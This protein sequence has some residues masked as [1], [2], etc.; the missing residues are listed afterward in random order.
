MSDSKAEGK[1]ETKR[2][3]IGWESRREVSTPFSKWTLGSRRTGATAAGETYIYTYNA[4]VDAP[5]RERAWHQVVYFFADARE[6]FVR[7]K[8]TE[9]WPPRDFGAADGREGR[10][11]VR[12][13]GRAEGVS[14]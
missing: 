14:P 12:S 9:F 5:D 4:V 8:P 13:E 1:I 6:K 11:G 2:F 3:W 7:E 10:E